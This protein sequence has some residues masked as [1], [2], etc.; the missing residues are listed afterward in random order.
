MLDNTTILL[1]SARH[2]S[3]NIHESYKRNL[4]CVTETNE[5][6]SFHRGVDVKASSENLRLITD[7]S[8]NLSFD[9]CESDDNVFGIV[10]HDFEEFVSVSDVLD[11]L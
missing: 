11:D 2:E 6:S 1:S 3:R 5:S 8:N 7:D 4:E 10:R 9:F